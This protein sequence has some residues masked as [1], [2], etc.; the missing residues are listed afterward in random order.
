MELASSCVVFGEQVLVSHTRLLIRLRGSRVAARVTRSREVQFLALSVET[1]ILKVK[2]AFKTG[3]SAD[4]S[5]STPFYELGSPN[6]KQGRSGT[7]RY[8]PPK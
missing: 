8:F 6:Q 4:E 3:N 7:S 2:T 5:N 1:E